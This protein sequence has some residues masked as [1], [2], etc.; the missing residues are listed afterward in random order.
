ML[1]SDRAAS[2]DNRHASKLCYGR[3]PQ[4]Y[5]NQLPA[6]TSLL[7]SSKYNDHIRYE[8]GEFDDGRKG[9]EEANSSPHGTESSIRVAVLVS[10]K[11]LAGAR[12]R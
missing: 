12:D 2:Y 9:H 3:Q 5:A 11:G 8:R 6:V 1:T 10:R 4:E 7:H